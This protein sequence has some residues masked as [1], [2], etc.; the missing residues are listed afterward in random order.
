MDATI[1]LASSSPRRRALLAMLGVGADVVPSEVDETLTDGWLPEEAVVKLARAK[2]EAVAKV[3]AD[4]RPILA[5]DTVVVGQGQILGKPTD[6]ADA[7]R[8]LQL[9][10]GKTFDVWSGIALHHEG[11]TITDL[12]HSRLL[13]DEL[14]DKGI[15]SYL[16][17]DT[18]TDKAGGLDVQ[19]EAKGFVE[20]ISGSRSN[21]YGLPLKPVIA[22]LKSAGIT[23]LEPGSSAL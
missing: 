20:L 3:T 11:E 17:A 8:M 7:I 1:V 6:R 5:A 2:A 4:L 19:G 21:V 15:S 14:T 12:A 23:L 22:L 13:M 9:M 16:A 10:S 18:W